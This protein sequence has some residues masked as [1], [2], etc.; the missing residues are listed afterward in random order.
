MHRS[1]II[2]FYRAEVY[3]PTNVKGKTP[4]FKF[5]G[6]LNPAGGLLTTVDDLAKVKFCRGGVFKAATIFEER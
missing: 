1:F 4:K 6:W 3:Q 5:W 2:S